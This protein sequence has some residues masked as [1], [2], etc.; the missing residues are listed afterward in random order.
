[1]LLPQVKLKHLQAWKQLDE[2]QVQADLLAQLD[3]IAANP[4]LELEAAAESLH[5]TLD[6]GL[7]A[8]EL[9]MTLDLKAEAAAAS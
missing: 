4:V 9:V 2:Q 8:Q 6:A 1:V 5:A 3:A 7:G